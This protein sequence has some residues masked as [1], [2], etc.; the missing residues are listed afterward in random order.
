MLVTAL[1]IASTRLRSFVAGGEGQKMARMWRPLEVKLGC[2]S[3]T[4]ER[5]PPLAFAYGVAARLDLG[6]HTP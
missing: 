3:C 1:A 2:Q 4:A 5:L 6:L